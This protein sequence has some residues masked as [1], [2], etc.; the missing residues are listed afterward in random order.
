MKCLKLYLYF[1]SLNNKI[2]LYHLNS[3][4]FVEKQL[5]KQTLFGGAQTKIKKRF[6]INALV[7]HYR[8]LQ[9]IK[10]VKLKETIIIKDFGGLTE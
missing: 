7:E 1:V 5:I 9:K 4:K 2:G 10:L 6:V 8:N 3:N